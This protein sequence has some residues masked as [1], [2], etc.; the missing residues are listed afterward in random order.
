MCHYQ[1]KAIAIM[2]IL[3]EDFFGKWGG[4]GLEFEALHVPALTEEVATTLEQL[5]KQ[6]LG[7][8]QLQINLESQTL[9]IMF[10]EGRVELLFCS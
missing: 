2:L 7:I 10:D 8:I 6:I 5:L 1:F 3:R 4:L 9:Q